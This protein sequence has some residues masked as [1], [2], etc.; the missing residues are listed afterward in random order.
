MQIRHVKIYEQHG[1]IFIS[2]FVK[3]TYD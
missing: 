2:C 3:V 1:E